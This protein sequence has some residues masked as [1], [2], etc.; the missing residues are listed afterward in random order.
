MH[1]TRCPKCAQRQLITETVIGQTIGCSR[2]ERTFTARPL[3]G[4]GHLRDVVYVTAAL[5]IG[6]V[7]AWLLMRGGA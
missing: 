1:L 4:L 7:V 6:G 5:V 3:S 2:C